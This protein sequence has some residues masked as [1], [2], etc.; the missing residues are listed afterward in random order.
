M[1]ATLEIGQIVNAAEVMEVFLGRMS[2]QPVGYGH[3]R[4]SHLVP[5]TPEGRTRYAAIPLDGNDEPVIFPDADGSEV[6][7]VLEDQD[8]TDPSTGERILMFSAE[9]S[10]MKL[11]D[12]EA[13]LALVRAVD[14]EAEAET[15]WLEEL[16]SEAPDDDE[17]DATTDFEIENLLAELFG[18]ADTEE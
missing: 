16:F 6:R 11:E 18:S 10:F 3:A 8:V 12:L 15:A 7:V 14:P 2:G 9:Q 5:P 17:V 4:I 1:S 13:E